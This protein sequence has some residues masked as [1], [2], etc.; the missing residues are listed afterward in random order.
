MEQICS[1]S[2]LPALFAERCLVVA[3]GS[4][5]NMLVLNSMVIVTF[6]GV[7]E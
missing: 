4:N 2:R 3:D 7:L 5:R 6:S 1:R